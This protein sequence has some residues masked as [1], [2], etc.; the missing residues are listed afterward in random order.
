MINRERQH[1]GEKKRLE[2]RSKDSS[3][4]PQMVQTD[5]GQTVFAVD[6]VSIEILNLTYRFDQRPIL[7]NVNA[8]F[9]Q[10]RLYAFV[11]PP[12]QGKSTLLKLMGGVLLPNETSNGSI[13]V[14]P[15]LRVLHLSQD[16]FFLG[17]TLLKNLVFNTS[18]EKVG[19]LERIRKICE[20]LNFP[21]S[22]LAHLQDAQEPSQMTARSEVFR[23]WVSSLSYTDFARINL[24]RAFIMNPECL[25]L[26]KPA[27]AFD[28]SEARAIIKLLRLHVDE[29]GLDLPE[30]KRHFRRNR[31]VFFTAA[32]MDAIEHADM[33]YEVST[34]HGTLPISKE[35][36]VRNLQ[37]WS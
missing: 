11:G 22:L 3:K 14:P 6:L 4:P 1:H 15:H 35:Q 8:S 2:A 27:L 23:Q 18:M 32:S 25:V 19:G 21:P 20:L 9:P 16:T 34:K 17:T 5:A 12:H 13:F 33:I 7:R 30:E 26:H 29:R 31:T 24:A 28:D 10:G 36:A 37:S